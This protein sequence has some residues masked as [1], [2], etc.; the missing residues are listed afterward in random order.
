MTTTNDGSV[1]QRQI[2][3]YYMLYYVL[4][5]YI[6]PSN[7]CIILYM[8]SSDNGRWRNFISIP[9]NARKRWSWAHTFTITFSPEICHRVRIW[10]GSPQHMHSSTILVSVSMCSVCAR[11]TSPFIFCF[12]FSPGL[13]YS[14]TVIHP[15]HI[16]LFFSFGSHLFGR[17][18]R[19][20]PAMCSPS[21]IVFGRSVD[22][23]WT[24][25]RERT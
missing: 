18:Q 14:H 20:Y 1:A 24:S 10:Y 17:Q 3:L 25:G 5:I 13:W 4:Y 7:K 15:A 23:V 11:C 2:Y 6:W 9:W 16:F 21:R 8:L 19:R 22:L 12:S